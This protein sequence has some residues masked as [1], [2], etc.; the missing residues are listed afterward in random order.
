MDVDGA[1]LGY[2]TGFLFFGFGIIAL[3]VCVF[4]LPE[5]ARR[6]P[7]ELDEMYTKKI[8]PWRMSKYVTD[9]QKR[10][11]ARRAGNGTV[12]DAPQA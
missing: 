4:L 3:A 2:N 12:A 9:V 7:A 10:E 11:N 6:N 1:D 8:A 5:T